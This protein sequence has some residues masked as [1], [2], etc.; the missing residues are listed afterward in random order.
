ML[1]KRF[2]LPFCLLMMVTVS[3]FAQSQ[4]LIERNDSVRTVLSKIYPN[5]KQ[6]KSSSALLNLEFFTSGAASFTEGDFD[7]AAFKLSRLRVE[8]KGSFNDKFHY[9][10][11]HNFNSNGDI[12]S[13]DNLSS[14]VEYAY[15]SWT[16]SPKFR[17]TAGKQALGLGGYEVY[18]APIQVRQFSEFNSHVD[19]YN[20]G[21]TFSYFPVQS[22]ELAFQV[23]NNR[24]GKYSEVYPNGLPAGVT[25]SKM[26]L[27]GTFNWNGNFADNCFQTRYAASVGQLA[28]GANIYY[29]TAGNIWDKKPVF[30][31]FDVMYSREEIDSKGLVS[32]LQ[33]EVIEAPTTA[34]YVEY[35]TFIG[36]ID[37]RFHPNWNAYIKGTY[38]TSRVYKANGP[39]EK[40]LYRKTWTAQAC[41]EFFPMKTKE[42]TL[43]AH[44]QY[45]GHDLT[46]RARLMGGVNP[47]TQ[48]ISVGVHYIIPVF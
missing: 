45:L 32:A 30:A 8:I 37:Y 34:Q 14:N 1:M 46:K 42:L 11:R 44:A 7:E 13:T 39:F 36:D 24:T 27:I 2:F 43:F 3:G 5:L 9:H 29:L 22:Q 15:L 38:E 40:G 21:L 6:Y 20:T 4:A 10:Y 48:R 18:A 16:P 26:P 17:L 41:I 35:L 31:Y 23:V 12:H 33:G 28:K 47:D 25:E 19:C